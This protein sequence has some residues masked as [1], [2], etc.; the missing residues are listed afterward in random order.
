[1]SANVKWY[2]RYNRPFSRDFGTVESAR[3]FYR[4]L[5]SSDPRTMPGNGVFPSDAQPIFARFIART[6]EGVI[7]LGE[8][9]PS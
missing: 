3:A 5:C 7:V 1:M 2:D 4:A 6:E 8:S 9:R